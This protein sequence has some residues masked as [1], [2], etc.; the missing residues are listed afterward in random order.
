[1]KYTKKFNILPKKV[2][3]IFVLHMIN[4]NCLV[5]NAISAKKACAE[6]V[7]AACTE[8]SV[9]QA[10]TDQTDSVYHI[11]AKDQKFYLWYIN[12]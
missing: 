8:G 10:A 3:I 9:H 12:L 6:T 5:S 7:C 4:Y 2:P 11:H 1:M